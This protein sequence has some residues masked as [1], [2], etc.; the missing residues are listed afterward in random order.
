V[1]KDLPTSDVIS[2]IAE[3]SGFV[4]FI[5]TCADAFDNKKQLKKIEKTI[6]CFMIFYLKIILN[7][8]ISGAINIIFDVIHVI[9]KF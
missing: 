9:L 5:P 3:A 8:K 4:V 1:L 2:R 6:R 7:I